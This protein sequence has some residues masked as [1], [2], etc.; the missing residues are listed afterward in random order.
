MLRSQHRRRP[1]LLGFGQGPFGFIEFLLSNDHRLLGF[2]ERLYGVAKR[3]LFVE[4]QLGV[5]GFAIVEFLALAVSTS[6][7][8]ADN[9]SRQVMRISFILA[10]STAFQ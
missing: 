6:A 7:R 3:G 5:E 9:T 2:I 8:Q 1:L 10:F 4:G